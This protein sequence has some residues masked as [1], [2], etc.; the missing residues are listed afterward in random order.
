MI[1]YQGDEMR[2]AAEVSRDFSAAV[3]LLIRIVIV[4][5]KSEPISIYEIVR[6]CYVWLPVGE[7]VRRK[8]LTPSFALQ[9][10]AN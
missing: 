1:D 7:S 5:N 8:L 6:I 9:N 3:H 4:K 2:K 10:V